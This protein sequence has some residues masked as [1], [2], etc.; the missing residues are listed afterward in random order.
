MP[1]QAVAD[2]LRCEYPEMKNIPV[3]E[4]GKGY[5]GFE[6]FETGNEGCRTLIVGYPEGRYRVEASKAVKATGTEWRSLRDSVVDTAK[7]FETYL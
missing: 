1:P 4:P 7:A 5:V 6:D 3:G 2:I